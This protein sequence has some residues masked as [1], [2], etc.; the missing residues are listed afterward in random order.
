MIALPLCSLVAARQIRGP[1][2]A[3][4]P[5]WTDSTNKGKKAFPQG[6]AKNGSTLGY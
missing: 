2:L 5:F 3:Q 6:F 4:L 1:V